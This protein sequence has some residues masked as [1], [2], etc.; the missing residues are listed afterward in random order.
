MFSV[1][2][3]IGDHRGLS[4]PV[5]PAEMSIG[6]QYKWFFRDVCGAVSKI[7]LDTFR[8]FSGD[9]RQLLTKKSRVLHK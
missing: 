9:R 1:S 7:T 6:V 4:Q 8:V 5:L 2:G 3:V